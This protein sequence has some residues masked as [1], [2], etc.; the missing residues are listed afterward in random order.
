MTADNSRTL[1]DKLKTTSDECTARHPEGSLCVTVGEAVGGRR[2][3][4]DGKRLP[5]RERE[6][7]G[8]AQP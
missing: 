1:G 4:R 2:A 7:D 5:E 8:R 3:W 6:R